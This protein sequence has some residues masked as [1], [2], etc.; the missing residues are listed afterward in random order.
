MID[1]DST[2]AAIYGDLADRDAEGPQN[3]IFASEHLKDVGIT[4]NKYLDAASRRNGEG[5]HN[6]VVFDDEAIKILKRYEDE[7]PLFQRAKGKPVESLALPGMDRDIE[8]NKES[9]AKEQGKALTDRLREP[10][11]NVDAAAGRMEQHSPL[12]SGTDANPQ[13]SLFQ[14]SPKD[15]SPVIPFPDRGAKSESELD[16]SIKKSQE[17]HGQQKPGFTPANRAAETALDERLAAT[18]P[19]EGQGPGGTLPFVERQ[20]FAEASAKRD[21]ELDDLFANAV[22]RKPDAA[23][24]PNLK[25]LKSIAQSMEEW[26]RGAGKLANFETMEDWSKART[27]KL[28]AVLNERKESEFWNAKQQ[29]VY[30]R[31]VRDQ[32]EE[33]K[34]TRAADRAARAERMAGNPVARSVKDL[35][36]EMRNAP[37][38][39]KGTMLDR[40]ANWTKDTIDESVGRSGAAI[41]KIPDGFQKAWAWSKATTAA[42]VH[43]YLHPLEQTDWKKSAGQMQLA[44]A[45]TSLRLHDLAKELKT[46]APKPLDR[47]AMTHYMEAGGDQNK[48]RQ[49]AMGAKTNAIKSLNN[50][51]LS[52]ETKNYLRDA[53]DHYEAAQKLTP[54]QKQLATQLRQHFDDMLE[55]AKEN[56]LLEYGYRNYVMHLYEKAEAANLLNM[57]DTMDLQPNPNFIKK[58][59]FD[60]FYS[61][62]QA[63]IKPKSKDIGYLLTAYDKSMNQAIA[64]R[65]FMRSLLDAKAPDGRPIAA[66]KMRGGWVIAKEGEAPQVLRQRARPAS[67]EGY[68]D[69][70][71][72]QLR[73]FLFKPTTEDLAGF[74]PKLFDE[75]PDKLAFKGDLIIHPRYASQVEDLLTPSW[76]ERGNSWPQKLG[77]GLQTISGI[78]KE[79]MTAAAPF[80]MVQLGVHG[81]EHLVNPFKVPDIDLSGK[82][83]ESQV[84]RLLAS[85]GLALVNY[86]AE[87]LFGTKAFAGIAEHIPF[88]NKAMDTVQAFSHWQFQDY[89]PRLKM[90]MAVD[91]FK[92]NTEKYGNKLS[93]DQIAEL[94]AKE[95]NAAF[96]NLNTMFDSVPRT[97][98]FKSLL[99]LATFAPDFLESRIRFVGQALTPYGGEQR[100]AL[101]R[102]ALAMYIAARVGNALI[103]NGDAK[104]DPAHAFSLVINGKEYAMRTV[105]GDLLHAV[106]DPRGFIYNRLNPLTTRPMV[107]FLSGR[108]QMGRQLTAG[109]QAKNLAKNILPFGVQKVIQTPDESLL[110]S[111]LTSAGVNAKNDRTPIE[112]KVH[113]MYLANLP[114]SPVDEEKLA[115]SRQLRQHEDAMREGREGP[116][117]VWKLVDKGEISPAQAARTIKRSNESRLSI[118]FKALHLD[119]AAE[120]YEDLIKEAKHPKIYPHVAM[121]LNEITPEMQYK[122]T[123]DLASLP[124]A[125][126]DKWA[127]KLDALLNQAPL[128]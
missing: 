9:A 122:R 55:I 39:A 64:S 68:R 22:G 21:R 108:D 65:N 1:D 102:G 117:E 69:F 19:A 101:A 46:A 87:G 53:V 25:P 95:S 84:Q 10:G 120:V 96:G 100:A 63:G 88:V 78:A 67:L 99:K 40:V 11:K 127:D 71:R 119:Q 86:D 26:K 29:A 123:H 57:V 128:Q 125:D 13:F 83:A 111:I 32:D 20:K 45:E 126:R 49:W 66:I 94:T 33:L 41:E 36:D 27:E 50:P 98:T 116:N 2:G 56:G 38:P 82:S 15:R 12:F 80:H 48:L 112:D 7:A 118:E 70:D 18:P 75:D 35:V 90:K 43:D 37:K 31:A 105:Q 81:T 28:K 110:N 103:N 54:E 42:L 79:S 51:L 104:W 14:K 30:D 8:A 60:T 74:D 121:A 73:N 4:G 97:K 91:A 115:E 24:R 17:E 34:A 77:K 93:E 72:P 23:P 92:R 5:T 47:I 6:Y 61:A 3:A 85:H 106:D 109:Q 76:F 44:Q 62:E 89:I 124:E 16:E 114:S 59:F 107:E 52:R 113:K 58:R